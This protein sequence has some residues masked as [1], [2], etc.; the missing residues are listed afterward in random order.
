LQQNINNEAK[1]RS[2]KDD[3]LNQRISNEVN[4]EQEA[5]IAGDNNLSSRVS[6]LENLP[7]QESLGVNQSWVNVT[8]SRA[9]GT[10]Y[11]NTS[12]RPIFIQISTPTNSA[13]NS[14]TINGLKIC[15]A[16]ASSNSA[17]PLVAIV[18]NNQSY[19]YEGLFFIWSELR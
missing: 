17:S 6:V 2:D 19:M 4:T 7:P 9:S 16:R 15:Q 10:T 1:I 8:S 5:R 18:P 11:I 3:W 14:I 12:G 13:D